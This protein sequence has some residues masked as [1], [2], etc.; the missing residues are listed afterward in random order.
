MKHAANI[1]CIMAAL[2]FAESAD[3]SNRTSI[4]I[5]AGQLGSAIVQ[6]GQ[7]TGSSIGTSDHSVTRISVRGLRGRMSVDEAIRR[8]L[9]GKPASA[10]QI[11][12]RSWRIVAATPTSERQVSTRAAKRVLRQETQAPETEAPVEIIVTASK[13]EMPLRLVPA[14]VSFLSGK[15][16]GAGI[17]AGGTA[18]I[19]DM[20]PNV[21]STHAGIGRNKLF[22]RGIADSGFTGPTQATVGQYFGEMRV[23]YNAPDPDLRL[24]DISSVEVIEGPQGTL[25]GAGS[26]GGIVRANPNL[27]NLSQTEAFASYAIAS[28]AHGSESVDGHMVVNV[29][30]VPDMVAVRLLGYGVREGGYVDDIGR[31][32][33]DVNGTHIVGGRA[34]I[35]IVPDDDWRVDLSGIGQSI[36]SDD[37]QY[38]QRGF[39]GISRR[40]PMAQKFG[41]DYWLAN[42]RVTGNIGDMR[43]MS[44]IGVVY[45]DLVENYDATRLRDEPTL[46]RQEN[47]I[48]LFST[49]HRLS[50]DYVEGGGWLIGASY[51]QSVSRLK[52]GLIPAAESVPYPGVE[53]RLSEW[54][55]F[56]EATIG[57]VRN[58][59]LT[60]GGRISSAKLSGHASD[61]P[62]FFDLAG[63]QQQAERSETT[64]LPSVAIAATP[65]GNL[66]AF[67][68]FQQ[69]FRPGGLAI[70]GLSIRHFRNDRTSTIE[71]G[72]RFGDLARDRFAIMGTVAYTD[73]RGIQAD[74]TDGLG[75]PTTANI[76]DGDILS[77]QGQFSAK[78][79]DRL[80]VDAAFIYS[81]S[82][83]DSP[84]PQAQVFLTTA[85]EQTPALL[86]T[87]PNVA[88]FGARA[89]ATYRQPLSR[90][91]D[92]IIAS[93]VRY[94][95]K[96]RLGIGP[97]LGA[98]QGGYLQS[99]FGLKWERGWGHMFVNV[100]NVFDTVGNR[101]AL[102]TPFA[103]PDGDE[104]TPL[105]PRTIMIGFNFG[106]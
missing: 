15:L 33:K 19:L 53:N 76:G 21:T 70:D 75:F 28:T 12:E 52:R 71:S 99:N 37:A 56:G 11:N 23:N 45:H 6:L 85:A 57:I 94:V 3:A 9:K 78:P 20:L 35:G 40:S 48:S 60:V 24:Y 100:S 87:V 50:K 46:F 54:A 59:N 49:E 98:E 80:T 7:Q 34:A 4:D 73:W 91:S 97:V 32:L 36:R 83:L 43:L 67:I 62:V 102:G 51:I 27:P 31:S 82:R 101:Y 84:S 2:L 63:F 29:P 104:Y 72:F 44:S 68:R 106:L 39:Q 79:T 89:A 26:L 55:L 103:L 96:S 88:R 74:V 81:H 105:R 38:A 66:I 5:G 8:L 16:F 14:T 30:V 25:Y 69:G 65:F 90:D 86:L 42:M 22:I 93:S 92:L 17:D 1:L 77:F 41:S 10:I 64:F 13:R 61:V 47:R 58:I 95:G 18:A